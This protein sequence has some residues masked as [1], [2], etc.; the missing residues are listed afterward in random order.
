MPKRNRI[1]RKRKRITKDV[2]S[3]MIHR[4]NA[5]ASSS[6]IHVPFWAYSLHGTK[7]TRKNKSHTGR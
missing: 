1:T 5:S 2:I 7:K 4:P 3:P 6:H